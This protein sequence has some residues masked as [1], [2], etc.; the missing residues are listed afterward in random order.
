MTKIINQIRNQT[1]KKEEAKVFS[2]IRSESPSRTPVLSVWVGSGPPCSGPGLTVLHS[3]LH[4]VFY[5][6]NELIQD[7]SL[8]ASAH[9]RGPEFNF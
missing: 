2:L 6:E 1:R 8:Q 3:I 5:F 4:Q 7:V 9:S